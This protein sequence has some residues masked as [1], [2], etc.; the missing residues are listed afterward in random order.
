MT[1]AGGMHGLSHAKRA[2]YSPTHHNPHVCGTF[3]VRVGSRAGW[4]RA[5]CVSLCSWG[6]AAARSE[7]LPRRI[8]PLRL[9]S[10]NARVMVS[11]FPRYMGTL[12]IADLA[13]RF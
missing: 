8:M 6:A 12:H 13:E 9:H 7:G 1:L 11:N 2:G 5:V 10:I 3:R 4:Q